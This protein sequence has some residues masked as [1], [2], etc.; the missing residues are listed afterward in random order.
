MRKNNTDA[1]HEATIED[2]R[3][4]VASCKVQGLS[5]RQ[6][7]VQLTKDRC[8]NPDTKKPW[9][10][11]AI[12]ADLVALTTRWKA[13]ALGDITEAKAQELARLDELEREAWAAWR[14]GMGRK[15]IRTTKTGGINGPEVSIRTEVL[16]GDPRYLATVLDCQQRR[17]KLLGLDA[18]AKVEASGP[19]GGP[20]PLGH[21]DLSR[22]STEELATMAELVMKAGSDAAAHP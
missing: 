3:A 15:Q 12:H 9:S 21:L 11:Q 17:A 22:L 7:I 10:V 13:E 2:R 5:I 1:K 19:G 6:T 16:N 8:F 4:R 18:P 14:R 20:I